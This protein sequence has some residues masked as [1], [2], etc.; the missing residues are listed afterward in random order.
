MIEVRV[1]LSADGQYCVEYREVALINPNPNQVE[2]WH[3]FRTVSYSRDARRIADTLR[4]IGLEGKEVY[5]A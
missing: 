5:R 1:M 3:H 2:K 4:V